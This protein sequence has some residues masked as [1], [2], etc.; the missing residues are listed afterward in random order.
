MKTE[1]KN[2]WLAAL[3]SGEFQPGRGYMRQRTSDS[4]EGPWVTKHCC[5][6][7]LCELYIREVEPEKDLKNLFPD[8]RLTTSLLP[9]EVRKWSGLT[10]PMRMEEL[11]QLND[12]LFKYPVDLIERL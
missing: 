11:A 8:S 5:L 7:V 1:I 2:K 3:K 6:G 4:M 9:A 10:N 12:Q